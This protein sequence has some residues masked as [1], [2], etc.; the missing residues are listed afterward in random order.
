MSQYLMDL[1]GSEEEQESQQSLHLELED[2]E[3]D[4][5][6]CSDVD[7]NVTP[8]PTKKKKRARVL[9]PLSPNIDAGSD[10][11]SILKSKEKRTQ[12]SW[13]KEYEATRTPSTCGKKSSLGALRRSPRK[14][15]SSTREMMEESDKEFE[16]DADTPSSSWTVTKVENVPPPD[17]SKSSIQGQLKE[18]QATQKE[19]LST[20]KVVRN[21]I[22]DLKREWEKRKEEAPETISVPNRIRNN[23]KEFYTCG[24]DRELAWDFKK[25]FNDEANA[26]MTEFIKKSVKGVAPDVSSEVL[27]AAV[28]R[29]FTSKKEGATRKAKNKDVL[30]K[31][32]QAT[33]ERKKEKVRRRLAATDKKKNWTEEKR[34]SVRK[35][36]NTKQAYKYMSSDEEGVDGFLSHPYSWESDTWK[37]VKESLDAKYLETC[38]P[39]SRRL[40]QKRTTGTTKEQPTPDLDEEFSWIFK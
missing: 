24:E 8:T 38:P 28:K 11:D 18:M 32:R 6:E 36:L 3:I 2:T 13:N 1:S 23:V 31:Q 26:E 5:L 7:S 20:M 30:H 35:F 34:A 40:L 12:S 22:R 37:H 4:S 14:R 15:P 9:R 27:E 29:Y 16:T 19:I 10:S 33:Y 17:S 21:E 39:R 25:R